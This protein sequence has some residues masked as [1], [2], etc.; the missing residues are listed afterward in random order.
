MALGASTGRIVRQLMT[1]S[2]SL[3]LAG[4][5]AGLLL[6]M[7]IVPVLARTA[8]APASID[9]APDVRVYLFLAVVSVLAGLG[10]GLAPARHAI[11]DNFGR[12]LKAPR[13][14]GSP[15]ASRLRSGLIGVQAAASLML[16][17]LAALFARATIRATQVDVG[18]DADRLLTVSAAFGRGTYDANG[19]RAYWDLA[20]DRVGGLPG[21]VAATL[22]EHTPFG[23]G[24][25]V[26]VFRRAGSRYTI[27]FNE[28]RADY[29]EVL[30]LRVL[31]G[32]T[33]TDREVIDSAP[34]A[35]VSE[36]IARDFFGDEDPL[37]QSLERVTG[38][39]G[40][41]IIGVVSSVV[42]ARLR[43]LSSPTVYQPMRSVQTARLVIRTAGAPEALIQSVRSALHPLDPRIRLSI[44]RV[45]DGLERQ[46]D[47]ARTLAWLA[48]ALAAVALVLAIVGIYGVTAFAVGQRTQEIGVRMALGATVPEIERLLLSD[49]LRPV[50][51][52][53]VAG[54]AAALLGSR[55]FI[56]VLY[57]MSPADPIAFGAAILLLL[58]AA[59]AAVLFPSR[60]AAEVDP[61]AVL[62]Q[63]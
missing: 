16:L 3:G 4:G 46:V 40:T 49:S 54:V 45:A 13:A 24:N 38:E 29:F 41:I 17:V 15:Q 37:G 63:V 47:E 53:L 5:A 61:A 2:L 26:M 33:Y 7:W 9:F 8:R 19:A 60:R 52:G 55:V 58:S 42:T 10:A 21:V 18:F 62:R 36:A 59:T 48:A 28:T 51:Y 31:R 25:R 34:V 12:A 50:A 43:E 20:L 57:G 35:V 14:G 23:D 22:A 6:T 11:R 27:Y 30:R 56:G 44:G 1:E 32:R 39:P